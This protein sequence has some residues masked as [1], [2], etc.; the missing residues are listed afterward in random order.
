M[1]DVE[2]SFTKADMRPAFVLIDVKDADFQ[3]VK[4]QRGPDVPTFV[5]KDVEGFSTNQCWQVPDKR[6]ERVT[7]DKL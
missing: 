5:L 4:A 1:S 6:L 3:H 7:L 2:V